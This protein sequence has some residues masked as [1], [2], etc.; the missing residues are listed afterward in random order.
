MTFWRE[1]LDVIIHVVGH[2]Y[3][4]HAIKCHSTRREL[5]LTRSIRAEQLKL[6]A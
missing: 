6:P 4:P 5:P 2:Y 3:V 1:F